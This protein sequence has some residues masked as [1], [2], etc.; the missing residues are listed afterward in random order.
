MKT[1][2]NKWTDRDV[3]AHWDS[4]A[5]IYVRENEKVKNTHDQRFRESIRYLELR[6]GMKI[7]NITSRDAEAG[8]FIIQ[9][10]PSSEVIHAEISAGLMKVAKKLRP[11]A[12]QVKL[13]NYSG[14][15]FKDAEFDRVLSL[16]TLEHVSEPLRFLMELHRVSTGDARLVLSCPPATSEIPYRFYTSVFGGHGEGPHRF[17]PSKEV[18]WM[19]SETNWKLLVHKGTILVPVGP[20]WLQNFGE[21]IIDRMQGT[22]IAELGIRQFYVC[23]KA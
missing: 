11:A 18:R 4:V 12:I 19:L 13:E 16:E 10:Q 15:P 1:T 8:D 22:F 5:A 2:R 14:L 7:L 9:E 21:K 23:E 3:E 17:L 20:A 6:P